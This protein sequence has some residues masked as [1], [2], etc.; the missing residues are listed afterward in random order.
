MGPGFPAL[1]SVCLS[2]PAAFISVNEQGSWWHLTFFIHAPAAVLGVW[3]VATG[4]QLKVAGAG[5]QLVLHAEDHA[6]Q[7]P[8]RADSRKEEDPWFNTQVDRPKYPNDRS[9]HE[10]SPADYLH[11]ED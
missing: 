1:K 11:L 9:H 6:E 5:Q 10:V 8:C 4:A 7:Q 2:I 3:C